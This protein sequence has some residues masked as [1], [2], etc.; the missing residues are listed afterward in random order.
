MANLLLTYIIWKKNIEAIFITQ[1]QTTTTS[2]TT[3]IIPISNTSINEIFLN[4]DCGIKTR[5]L[6]PNMTQESLL[7]KGR[8][9]ILSHV[10]G[11]IHCRNIQ[12]LAWC[13]SENQ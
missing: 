7:Q 1:N 8:V 4:L 13:Q 12:I 2:L 3:V 5:I 9:H 11:Y 10:G 6:L